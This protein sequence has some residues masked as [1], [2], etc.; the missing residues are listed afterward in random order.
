MAGMV[1]GF[2]VTVVWVV[3]FKERFLDL[4]EMIPG[5]IAGFACCVGVSLV[6]PVDEAAVAD[7][8]AVREAVGP[9]F[10]PRR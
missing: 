6:T 5:F 4:Y 2:V 3:A 7:L 10:G 8:E 1:G 9:V